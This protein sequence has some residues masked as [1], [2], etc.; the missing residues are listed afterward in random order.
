VGTLTGGDTC[1]SKVM[2][3]AFG[4]EGGA[5]PRFGM[6]LASTIVKFILITE[7]YSEVGE[8]MH[9]WM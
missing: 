6:M 7:I 3:A 8:D 2:L 5:A 9:A 4:A 1:I